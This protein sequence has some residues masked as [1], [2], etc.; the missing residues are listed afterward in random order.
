VTTNSY[1]TKHKKFDTSS[2]TNEQLVQT[3]EEY[4]KRLTRAEASLRQYIAFRESWSKSKTG[5]TKQEVIGH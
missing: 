2:L 1:S 3:T 4:N 5:K